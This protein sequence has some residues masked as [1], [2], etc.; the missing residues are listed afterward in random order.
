MMAKNRGDT[1]NRRH[2]FRVAAAGATAAAVPTATAA[3]APAPV[4]NHKARTATE[5]LKSVVEEVIGGASFGGWT[6]SDIPTDFLCM[7]R[8]HV[9]CSRAFF[10]ELLSEHHIEYERDSD[11]ITDAWIPGLEHVA[12]YCDPT[13]MD[14]TQ[15]HRGFVVCDPRRRNCLWYGD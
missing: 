1:M 12:I 14:F 15:I 5:R 3:P 2:F 10:D 9:Q 7:L 8:I 6:G 4:P 13:S 11:A